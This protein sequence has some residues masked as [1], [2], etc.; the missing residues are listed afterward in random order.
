[1]TRINGFGISILAAAISAVNVG[2]AVAAEGPA[3]D[4]EVIVTGVAQP[5]TK[6]S[7][8]NS[9]TALPASDIENFAPRSTAE[10]FRNLPGVQAEA[11]G[12][13]ANANIKVRGLPIS[14]GGAR[15]LSIQEDST[16]SLLIGDMEFATSDSFLRFDNNVRSVQAI[17][18]G[19]GST[20]APNSPGG[21][22]NF[23]S[24]DGSDEGG[25]VAYTTGLDY[26]SNRVDFD[27]GKPL[28]DGWKYHVGGFVRHGEGPR[29]VPDD[30]EKGYQIKAN[31]TKDLE[32]GFVRFHF[33]RLDDNV[34]T[35]LPVPAVADGNGGFTEVGV[36][37]GDGSLYLQGNDILNREGGRES[38]SLTNGFSSEVTTLGFEGELDINDTTSFGFLHKMNQISG[39]FVSPFPAEVYT[40][41][42]GDTAAR[43]HYF[44]TKLDSLDNMFTDLNIKKEFETVS[45]KA[46]VFRGVQDYDAQW[47]WNTYFV[48]LDGALTPTTGPA[49]EPSF[50]A[51]HSLWGDCCSRTYDIEIENI[52]PYISLTGDIGE[53]LTWDASLRRD[54]WKV[55]GTYAFSG[56]ADADGYLTYGNASPVDYDLSYTSWSLGANYALTENSALFGSISEGGSATAPSRI[57]GS[58]LANGD[59]NAE[60]SG[61][62]TVEQIEVGYKYRGDNGSIYVTLFNAETQEAGGF[63]VT[64]QTVI[65]NS[66]D[67]KGIEVEGE[68]DFGNGFAVAGGFT[69]TDA[70]ITESNVAAN[71]GN[72]PR[73]QADFI[74]NITPSYTNDKHNVGLNIVGTD[75]TYIQ[76]SNE[77][78]FDG[79]VV[80]N[81]FWNY[82]FGQ[83]MSLS[84]NVNNLFDEEGFSEGEEGGPFAAGDFVRIRPIN[85]RT[86]SLTLRHFF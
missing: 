73:R 56:P 69:Y 60:K 57:T 55:D 76:D 48:K 9:V 66:Y 38:T 82:D 7:S 35:Y 8:T 75:D 25:S 62:S 52:A 5:T 24:N 15:Y 14:A 78:K 50:V 11:T 70:E 86:A 21:I 30:I 4:E 12:G 37:F 84:L 28:E 10:I 43:I 6:L 54:F 17:R 67:S 20:Q 53:N 22:I 64:T 39:Q 13:D 34:P 65:E 3:A 27:Y 77:A 19:A 61:Y 41:G 58:L 36:P 2:Y 46:G 81:L 79:Y 85:G 51:G 45:V 31:A 42:D 33:K 83:D 16:P 59:L 71:V 44:N 74:Y 47:G 1:M 26:D 40:D 63:E 18:G 23:I 49:A 80:T 68:Y 32:N 29:D 72:T